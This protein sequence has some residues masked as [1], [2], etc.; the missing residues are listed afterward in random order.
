[1]KTVNTIVGLLMVIGLVTGCATSVPLAECHV[2]LKAPLGKAMAIVED[3]L[4]QDCA[5]EF[6]TYQAQLM[7]IAVDNPHADNKREFSD[8]LVRV[9]N[10]GTIS[11]RQAS[12]I[13]NRYFN[14]KFV[15]LAGEY[16]TCSQVCPV[17]RKVMTEMRQ[18][19]RDKE[20]GL[21]RASLDKAGYYRADHLLKESEIVLEAT[22]RACGHTES[23][24]ARLGFGGVR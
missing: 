23:D 3:K 5:Y 8:F 10:R 11:K 21:M 17:R 14:V 7:D 22:C 15:S 19:L 20:T 16:N 2:S 24:A 9:S 18:E 4:A 12:A 13:Y 6:E 1:M